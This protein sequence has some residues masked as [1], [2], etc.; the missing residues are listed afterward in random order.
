MQ[1]KDLR[2]GNLILINEKVYGCVSGTIQEIAYEELSPKKI[3]EWKPIV[4]NDNWLNNLGFVKEKNTKWHTKN[5][6]SI[7]LSTN[8]F[9]IY[10]NSGRKIVRAGIKYVHDLQNLYFALTGEE[11]ELKN[12][13]KP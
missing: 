12:E 8:S 11:L 10:G 4:L 7:S 3:N 1:S 6:I 2:I 13:S 5:I 9:I